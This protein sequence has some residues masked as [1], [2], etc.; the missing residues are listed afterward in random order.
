MANPIYEIN[1]PT[2]EQVTNLY[3]YGTTNVPVDGKRAADVENPVVRVDVNE[4]MNNGPGRFAHPLNVGVVRKFIE[5]NGTPLPTD[6]LFSKAYGS[7]YALP[8]GRY[9]LPSFQRTV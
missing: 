4:Y 6:T 5:N 3:L 2:A 7:I 1:N 9:D 8:A